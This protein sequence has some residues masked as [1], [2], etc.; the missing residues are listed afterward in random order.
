MKDNIEDLATEQNTFSCMMKKNV[1]VVFEDP[2]DKEKKGK[3]WT[4]V[5]VKDDGDFI[6][7][8]SEGDKKSFICKRFIVAISELPNPIW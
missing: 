8:M 1:R 6:Q 5:L 7:L 2:G 3:V 4:G